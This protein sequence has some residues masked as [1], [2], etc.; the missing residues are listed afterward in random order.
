MCEP[1]T[2]D[3]SFIT[4]KASDRQNLSLSHTY[5]HTSRLEE[6]RLHPDEG[7]V[8]VLW[9]T[10]VADTAEFIPNE[11]RESVLCRWPVYCFCSEV[12][13]HVEICH[14]SVI[15]TSWCRLLCP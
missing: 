14:L 15:A 2:N 4:L 9:Q 11:R 13:S 10:L 12:P 5:K 6:K 3:S 8:V 7:E 1:K